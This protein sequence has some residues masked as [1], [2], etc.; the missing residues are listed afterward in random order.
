[1]AKRRHA[2]RS[3][4]ISRFVVITYQKEG[5][6]ET[7]GK[8]GVQDYELQV[9][10]ASL[11]QWT[12]VAKEDTGRAV[13]TRVHDLSRPIDTDKI[14]LV[15]QRVAPLDGQARLLQLEAWGPSAR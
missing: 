3:A 15:I 14:R 9:W 6:P 10:D 13:K 12:T 7:A 5:T 11:G 8:W 4:A 1:M 2:S